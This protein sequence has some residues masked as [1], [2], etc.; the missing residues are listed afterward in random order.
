M[1]EVILETMKGFWDDAMVVLKCSIR[2]HFIIVVHPI[3]L[4]ISV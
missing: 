1:E 4:S 2:D 3:L